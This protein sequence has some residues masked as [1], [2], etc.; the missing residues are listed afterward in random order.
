[1]KYY[2]ERRVTPCII[3]ESAYLYLKTYINEARKLGES[4]NYGGSEN[5]YFKFC[6]ALNG[7]SAKDF[8]FGGAEPEA[9]IMIRTTAFEAITNRLRRLVDKTWDRT[10]PGEEKHDLSGQYDSLCEEIRQLDDNS[11]SW[12]GEEK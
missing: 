9:E 12:V 10:L 4:G 2:I 5:A 1:M 7:L 3:K 11:L 6:R 8:S